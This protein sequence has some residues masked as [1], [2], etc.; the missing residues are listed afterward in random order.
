MFKRTHRAAAV[1]VAAVVA[2]VSAGIAYSAIPDGSGKINGCYGKVLGVLRVI[3]SE[4]GETC[5]RVEA[6]ISWNQQGPQG[7]PGAD[8]AQGPPGPPG[9]QGPQGDQGPQG[10]P[11]AEG[12]QGPAGPAG[13]P[14]PSDAY[15]V[16]AASTV[17]IP[18]PTY[19]TIL[20]RHV[21]AG[22]YV[23]SASVLVHNFT[24][25]TVPVLCVIGSPSEFSPPYGARIDPFNSATAQGASSTTISL[26]L[27][28]VVGSAGEITL[29]CQ[30]NTG[31]PT[32]TAFA[33]ARQLTA[34]KVSELHEQDLAP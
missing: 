22:K 10:Q 26:T 6:P 27:T 4:A 30:T 23:I 33:D 17:T 2:V 20:S 8:G 31:V 5:S 18:T 19:T 25:A 12:A 13:P 34:I 3:D 21:P 32:Q 14:G 29:A 7:Q 11:G 15:S 1:V 16:E 24:T 28:T 9:P